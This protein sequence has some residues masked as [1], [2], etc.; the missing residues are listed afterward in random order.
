[1][2]TGSIDAAT[3][4]RYRDTLAARLKAIAEWAS[5]VGYPV[6]YLAPKL[7]GRMFLDDVHLTAEGNR[8][9]GRG[10]RRGH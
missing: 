1:M 7:P 4:Q 2:A 9:D 5:T 10:T 3:T 6:T 8:G